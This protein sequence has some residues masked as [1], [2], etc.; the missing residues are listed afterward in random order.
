MYPFN[1]VVEL[2]RRL[3]EIACSESARPE[4]PATLFW[5]H[6][7]SSRHAYAKHCTPTDKVRRVD[8]PRSWKDWYTKLTNASIPRYAVTVD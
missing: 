5:L 6:T 2:R 4:I 1:H 3:Y 8:N 7:F